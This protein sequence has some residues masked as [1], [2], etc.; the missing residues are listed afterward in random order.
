[1]NVKQQ[2]I[3]WPHYGSSIK[4]LKQKSSPLFSDMK[5]F[6]TDSW[7]DS[8]KKNYR[9]LPCIRRTFFRRNLAL[10]NPCVLYTKLEKFNIVPLSS[11]DQKLDEK[12]PLSGSCQHTNDH[13]HDKRGRK[14]ATRSR[15]ALVIQSFKKLHRR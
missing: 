1:M 3:D 10:K 5:S 13:Q 2:H 12:G 6:Q 7:E 9:N 8:W 14:S 11:E 4:I 15:Y